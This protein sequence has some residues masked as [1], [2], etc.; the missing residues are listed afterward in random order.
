MI[1]GLIAGTAASKAAIG[2]SAANWRFVLLS[3]R[4]RNPQR[5]AAVPPPFKKK[6]SGPKQK[7]LLH[8]AKGGFE[9]ILANSALGMNVWFATYFPPKLL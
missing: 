4:R 5:M 6:N 1:K 8:A 2:A 3:G 9:P 7:L